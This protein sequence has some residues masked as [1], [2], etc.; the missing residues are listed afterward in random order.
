MGKAALAMLPV[1][2]ESPAADK[3]R[4]SKRKR[5]VVPTVA[6]LLTRVGAVFIGHT[7]LIDQ[8]NAN[9]SESGFYGPLWCHCRDIG[10][11]GGYIFPTLFAGAALGT[12]AHL[13][14]SPNPGS[15][16]NCRYA[17]RCISRHHESSD[18]F[19]VVRDGTDAT[20]NFGSYCDRRR[21]QRI[22]HCRSYDEIGP[23]G[24]AV[25]DSRS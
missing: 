4:I 6:Q 18:L 9:R 23:G 16:S 24:L 14:F 5:H 3:H 2:S 10:W 13:V 19:S 12:A 15:H 25:Q 20:R 21:R 8:K 7:T 1:A 11:K 22:S 17:G